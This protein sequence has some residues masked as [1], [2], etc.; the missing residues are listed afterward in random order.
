M[1]T[2]TEQDLTSAFRQ[3]LPDLTSPRFTI[4]SKQSPYEYVEAFQE[5]HVPPWLYNLTETWK[6]LLQEPYKGISVDGTHFPTVVHI[7]G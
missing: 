3:Y 6:V 2:S 5:S 1:A 4:S 7:Q